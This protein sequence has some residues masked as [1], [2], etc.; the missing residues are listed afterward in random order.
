MKHHD[1]KIDQR[2]F[3][4]IIM[5][6]KTAE[7]RLNDRDF[8]TGDTMR[9]KVE[10]SGESAFCTITHVLTDVDGLHSD[11]AMISFRLGAGR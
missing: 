5:R 10:E 4:R 1:L 6:E 11:Y 8:Q 9:L 3:N 2:W 7:I